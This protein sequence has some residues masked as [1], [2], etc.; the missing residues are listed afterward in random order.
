MYRRIGMGVPLF[1]FTYCNTVD[2]IYVHNN[3]LADIC[4]E[5]VIGKKNC[6]NLTRIIQY[7]YRV[8]RIGFI[9]GF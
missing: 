8:N 2:I 3:V 1:C 4:A 6:L 7:L 5:V 9:D